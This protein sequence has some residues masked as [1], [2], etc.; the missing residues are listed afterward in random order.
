METRRYGTSG[1]QVRIEAAALEL[2]RRLALAEDRSLTKQMT[3]LIKE[4]YAARQATI[5]GT[6]A[7]VNPGYVA[8]T[9]T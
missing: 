7:A 8:T 1:S 6:P 5:D 3:V 9:L 2:L 4:G